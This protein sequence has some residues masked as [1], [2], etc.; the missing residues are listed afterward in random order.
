MCN[1]RN[2]PILVNFTTEI[3]QFEV[4]MHTEIFP[5]RLV[6]EI[7][8]FERKLKF[9][10][11]W[12][13]DHGFKTRGTQHHYRGVCGILPNI[14]V[15]F[16]WKGSGLHMVSNTHKSTFMDCYTIDPT[17]T[18]IDSAPEIPLLRCFSAMQWCLLY[19]GI[20]IVWS[21]WYVLSCTVFATILSMCN[22]ELNW[23]VTW[24]VTLIVKD[25]LFGFLIC[26]L[27]CLCSC[28]ENT[29]KVRLS[30]DIHYSQI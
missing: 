24:P 14:P 30:W 8:V 27:H 12:V 11:F 18:V 17:F 22:C 1:I 5:Q 7:W 26:F 16:W 4:H 10:F 13:L 15:A 2:K 6:L 28:P 3:S 25:L 29:G 23:G 19:R 20:Y 9:I 21:F